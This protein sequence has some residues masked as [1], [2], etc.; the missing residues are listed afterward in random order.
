MLGDVVD[1]RKVINVDERVL[2]VF[3][4]VSAPYAINQEI[5][6]HESLVSTL[7]ERKD[8]PI[9]LKVQLG[10]Y[11]Y[12]VHFVANATDKELFKVSKELIGRKQLVLQ[13]LGSH[14]KSLLAVLD[15]EH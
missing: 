2:L 15:E 8:N 5:Q 6:I 13:V 11:L 10:V 14:W 3:K 4:E 7:E 1:E 9:L 12:E